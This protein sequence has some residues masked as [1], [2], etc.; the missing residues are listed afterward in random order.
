[1]SRENQSR[2]NPWVPRKVFLT[3]GEEFTPNGCFNSLKWPRYARISP[4]NLVKVS[5][6]VPPHCELYGGGLELL[7]AG[8]MTFCVMSRCE[9][10][11]LWLSPGRGEGLLLPENSDDYGERTL[12][13]ITAMARSIRKLKIGSATRRPSSMPLPAIKIQSAPWGLKNILNTPEKKPTLPQS[14][15]SP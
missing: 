2:E 8:E 10:D 12:S 11:E 15:W 5:S 1:M 9:S 14:L 13:E 3:K 4:Q 6:I 7:S